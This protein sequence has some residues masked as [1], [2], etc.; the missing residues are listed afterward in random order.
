MKKRHSYTSYYC[1]YCGE[2]TEQHC[3]VCKK[4]VCENH[5][6]YIRENDRF[7]CLQHI[8]EETLKLLGYE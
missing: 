5:Y 7:I 6:L 4:D 1:D 8:S 2:V 3:S